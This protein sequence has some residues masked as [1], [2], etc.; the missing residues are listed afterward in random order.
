M[1]LLSPRNKY[2]YIRCILK[3]IALKDFNSTTIVI[4]LKLKVIL[5]DIE[6]LPR[7]IL[8]PPNHVSCLSK[9]VQANNNSYNATFFRLLKLLKDTKITHMSSTGKM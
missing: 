5:N 3:L 8:R 9:T 2:Q 1:Y 7:D 4:T 6:S